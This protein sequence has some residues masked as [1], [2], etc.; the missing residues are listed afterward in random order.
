M[1]LEPKH[2]S[3]VLHL[4]R[5]SCSGVSYLSLDYLVYLV[6]QVDVDKRRQCGDPGSCCELQCG[7][8]CMCWVCNGKSDAEVHDGDP[9]C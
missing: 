2:L 3:I 4:V 9:Q 7:V 6:E 1:E 5:N 8:L